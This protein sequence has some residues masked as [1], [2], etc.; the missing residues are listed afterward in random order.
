[1]MPEKRITAAS[2]LKRILACLI[3]GSLWLL[4]ACAPGGDY[5]PSPSSSYFS[6]PQPAYNYPDYYNYNGC[7]HSDCS[8]D[9][10]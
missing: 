4:P 2:K 5:G 8:P 9:L 3:L 7:L 1:M 6:P 10:P